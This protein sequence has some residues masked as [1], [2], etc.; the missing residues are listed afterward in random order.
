MGSSILNAG[1]EEKKEIGSFSGLVCGAGSE[2]AIHG[3]SNQSPCLVFLSGGLLVRG[4][5]EGKVAEPGQLLA[6]HRKDDPAEA[7]GRPTN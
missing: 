3:A 4:R 5:Q 6:M 7:R 2:M 1:Q